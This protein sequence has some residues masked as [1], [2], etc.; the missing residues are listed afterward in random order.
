MNKSEFIE[1]IKLSNGEVFHL[2]YHQNR[3]NNTFSHF[4]RRFGI[5]KVQLYLYIGI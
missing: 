3:I 5:D 4:F 2:E 1:T